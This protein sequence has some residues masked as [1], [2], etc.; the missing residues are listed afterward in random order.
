MP[1]DLSA[2]LNAVTADKH[3]GHVGLWLMH[4]EATRVEGLL[5]V[6]A[7]VVAGTGSLWAPVVIRLAHWL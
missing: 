3:P 6:T 1:D 2:R 7:P 4:R 5:T